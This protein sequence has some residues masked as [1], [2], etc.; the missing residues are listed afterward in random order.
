MEGKLYW[1]DTTANIIERVSL[2]GSEREV[3]YTGE[4][5][6]FFP[7]SVAYHDQWLFWSDNLKGNLE[8]VFINGSKSATDKSEVL[9]IEKPFISG[10]KVFHNI[11]QEETLICEIFNPSCP[12][13]CLNTPSKPVCLCGDGFSLNGSGTKCVPT[14]V[15][16]SVAEQCKRFDQF[17]CKNNE[18]CIPKI[19][20]CD[21]DHDCE[22]G[23]DEASGLEGPCNADCDLESYFKCDE[24]RCINRSLVCDGKVDCIDESD[25]DFVNCPNMTCIDKFFQCHVTKRCIPANWVCDRH[26]DCGPGDVSDEPDNCTKCEE[27]ECNNGICVAFDYICDGVDNCG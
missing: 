23:S 14:T 1:C 25:E 6:D 24:Q 19:Q 20:T 18:Q 15:N 3:L 21:G 16:Q 5:K 17:L 2:D 11:S 9:E 4:T 8:R 13:L 10:I 12:A 26:P 27:F 22:D 7:S